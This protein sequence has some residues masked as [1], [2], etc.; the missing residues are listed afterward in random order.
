MKNVKELCLAPPSKAAGYDIYWQAEG[1]KENAH[2]VF[3][4]GQLLKL[5]AAEYT[6]WIWL[7]S[8]CPFV[9]GIFA[10]GERKGW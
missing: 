10:V 8:L 3:E 6:S 1:K 7:H 2:A 9:T 4:T 5:T